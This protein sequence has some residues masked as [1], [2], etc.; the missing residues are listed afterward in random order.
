[1][2][3]RS[4]AEFD[5]MVSLLLQHE[6]SL[7]L[8]N[9]TPHPFKPDAVFPNNWFST[10]SD[11]HLI[12]Y[13]MAAQNRRT[14]VR[15]DVLEAISDKYTL[16]KRIDLQHKAN[17]NKFLEGTGSLVFDHENKKCFASVSSRTN[18]N[19]VEEVC[20]LLGYKSVIFSSYNAAGKLI[21]HTNMVLSI[22]NKF[23]VVCDD[24][25]VE[26]DYVLNELLDS[27]LEIIKITVEEM[28]SFGANM[29][30]L[31]NRKEQQLIMLSE[32]ALKVFR[33]EILTWLNNYGK[34]LPV[35][36]PTIEKVGGG[37]ARCMVAEIFKGKSTT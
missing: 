31:H 16:L 5:A 17:E 11:G 12:I 7:V 10:H 4:M 29:L 34:L 22:G 26:R 20:R 1:M 13:P 3:F 2:L 30:Q 23:A 6:V 14:E 35:S 8:V 19:L 28:L 32:A 33:P 21:Y 24:V 15:F 36:I 18:S 37:S 9:D 25:I 27:K